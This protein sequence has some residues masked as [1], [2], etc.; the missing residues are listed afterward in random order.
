MINRLSFLFLK[1]FHSAMAHSSTLSLLYSLTPKFLFISMLSGH[2]FFFFFFL[3]TRGFPE[4]V[5]FLDPDKRA[6]SSLYFKGACS[7]PPLPHLYYEASDWPRRHTYP[8]FALPTFLMRYWASWPYVFCV[9]CGQ[10]YVQNLAVKAEGL[11]QGCQR[12]PPCGL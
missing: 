9:G 7:L 12:L 11:S 10:G 6:P 2:E 4:A 1:V 8:K 3:T 5:L